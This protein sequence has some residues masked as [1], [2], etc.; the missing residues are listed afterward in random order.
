MDDNIPDMP[1]EIWRNFT[2]AIQ[3]MIAV[4]Y[5]RIKTLKSTELHSDDQHVLWTTSVLETIKVMSPVV[6]SDT[7]HVR[8]GWFRENITG[9]MVVAAVLA[10][11]FAYFGSQA[12]ATTVAGYL[13]I[14]K[15]LA[16]ALVGAAGTATVAAALKD[17]SK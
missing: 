4:E 7:R 2:P 9:L 5:V 8:F 15:L 13:D 1:E 14:A 16:G 6:A 3:K 17:G 12:E 11:V 10:I